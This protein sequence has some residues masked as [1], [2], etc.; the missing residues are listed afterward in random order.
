MMSWRTSSCRPSGAGSSWRIALQTW[1]IEVDGLTVVVD[2]GVATARLALDGGAGQ[3]ENGLPGCTAE[4]GCRPGRCR[5]RDQHPSA[6]RSRRLEYR[7]RRRCGAPTFPNARYL[8]PEADYRHF[9]P[10]AMRSAR[11]RKPKTSDRPGACPNVFADSIS[12]V[13]EHIELW[14]DDYELSESVRLR[15]A[16]GHTPD[17]RWCGWIRKPAVLVGDLTHCLVQLHRPNDPCVGRRLR[18]AAVTRKRGAD[19]GLAAARCGHT[20]ALPG[21]WRATVVARGDAFMVDDWLS[22]RRSSPRGTG[23]EALG[24]RRCA[25]RRVAL[26]NVVVA[27]QT[28]LARLLHAHQ[29]RC[30]VVWTR[31]D[32]RTG[33]LARIQRPDRLVGGG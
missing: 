28:C 32:C 22:C 14:S 10:T 30:L 33:D 25:G 26:Q 1:V 3:P 23:L 9:I 4:C 18:D 31:G 21:A 19:R 7:A 2:T 20:G 15:P 29:H 6:L 27:L 16:P 11:S 13:Q 24:R 5:R 12:P 8:M 17:R